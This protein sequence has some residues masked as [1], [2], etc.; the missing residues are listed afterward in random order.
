ML[1]KTNRGWTIPEGDKK[2]TWECMRLELHINKIILHSEFYFHPE[3]DTQDR[4]IYILHC[5]DVLTKTFSLPKIE[6][7]IRNW[8]YANCELR[9][10]Y[11]GTSNTCFSGLQVI[12][13]FCTPLA[14]V[15]NNINYIRL[16]SLHPANQIS[17][18]LDICVLDI[19]KG[20]VD[21]VKDWSNFYEF[22]A[23]FGKH[24][25]L[26]LNN[27]DFKYKTKYDSFGKEVCR[28]L[29]KEVK[30]MMNWLYLYDGDMIAQF[31]TEADLGFL[32]LKFKFFW[33]NY[34]ESPHKMLFPVHSN[35]YNPQ[36]LDGIVI[37][38]KCIL[39][40][41]SQIIDDVIPTRF[42][43]ELMYRATINGVEKSAAYIKSKACISHSEL[44]YEAPKAPKTPT[45]G[46]ISLAKQ[47]MPAPKYVFEP[48]CKY[49]IADLLKFD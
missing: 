48:E 30:D 8:H 43:L 13:N 39:V 2:Q 34:I 41:E 47:L 15:K 18:I 31:L 29:E 7:H 10:L 35:K 16:G 44:N 32:G 27:R 22:H 25:L 1:V 21:I 28:E 3:T 9:R 24:M 49:I 11:W 40:F 14:D 20:S 4:E 33:A 19:S 12:T 36:E 17:D 26:N 42:M 46:N 5:V 45:D 38:P 23:L 6:V 37:E